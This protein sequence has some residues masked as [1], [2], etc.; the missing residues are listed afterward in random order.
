MTAFK[1]GVSQWR[2]VY[3]VESTKS[4]QVSTTGRARVAVGFLAGHAYEQPILLQDHDTKFDGAF[5]AVLCDK[6]AR[7]QKVGPR[8]PNLNAVAERTW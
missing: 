7:V 1:N 2:R 4:T 5:N 3:I 8:A 6:G